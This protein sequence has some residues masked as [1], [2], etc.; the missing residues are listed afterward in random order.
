MPP[1][2]NTGRKGSHRQ[3]RPGSGG[4]AELGDRFEK[5]SAH[6][7]GLTDLARVQG[8]SW[9]GKEL[10]SAITEPSLLEWG[11]RLVHQEVTPPSAELRDPL[12]CCHVAER[13]SSWMRKGRKDPVK[14]RGQRARDQEAGGKE[15]C[16]QGASAEEQN[17]EDTQR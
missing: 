17:H 9:D 13:E 12:Q 3:G 6:S 15:P 16:R 8:L 11:E 5:E 10:S 1:V 2:Q 14:R 7:C 4:T